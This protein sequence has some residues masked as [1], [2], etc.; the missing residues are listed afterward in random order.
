MNRSVVTQQKHYEKSNG[1]AGESEDAAADATAIAG[2]EECPE[3]G[4][5]CRRKDNLIEM[6]V[7]CVTTGVRYQHWHCQ[8][9][10]FNG[11][12]SLAKTETNENLSNIVSYHHVTCT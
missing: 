10:S 6:L 8:H 11:H 5:V 12:F 2:G 9:L 7:V 3:V 4:M 1:T